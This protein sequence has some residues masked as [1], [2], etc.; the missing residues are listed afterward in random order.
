MTSKK[1][2]NVGDRVR[3]THG[4][5]KGEVGYITQYGGYDTFNEDTLY[6]IRA[7]HVDVSFGSFFSEYLEIIEEEDV[8]DRKW[9][10]RWLSTAFLYSSWSKD[11]STQCGAT[12]VD[13]LLNV[14]LAHGY[15]GFPRGI[16]DDDRV[17]NRDKK[18]LMTAHAEANAIFTAARLGIKLEGAT[19]YSTWPCCSHCCVAVIQAGIARVVYPL[20]EYPERWRESF[21]TGS[22]ILVEA[23]IEVDPVNIN[24]LDILSQK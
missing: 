8:R 23:G 3:I 20:M 16:A 6:T 17:H 2:L 1:K 24:G 4:L 10:I 18:L 7:E 5:H 14:Q 12:I 9:D 15:N 11:P 13:P 22:D 19:L 21:Q